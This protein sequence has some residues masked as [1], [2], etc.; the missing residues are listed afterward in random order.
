MNVMGSDASA[1][2]CN[3]VEAKAKNKEVIIVIQ[4]NV[5]LGKRILARICSILF[6]F[7]YYLFFLTISIVS[8]A[9]EA[10]K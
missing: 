1:R 3:A 10:E 9:K 4:L 5:T 7:F 8:K 6:L 2:F